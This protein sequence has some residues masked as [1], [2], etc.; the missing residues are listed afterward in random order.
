MH[1]DSALVSTAQAN[2]LCSFHVM[3]FAAVKQRQRV[4]SSQPTVDNSNYD[5]GYIMLPSRSSRI[6]V[7]RFHECLCRLQVLKKLW[8]SKFD[9]IRCV[10]EICLQDH[11]TEDRLCPR[12][13]R[14]IFHA[15]AKSDRFGYMDERSTDGCGCWIDNSEGLGYAIASGFGADER[16][17]R[18]TGKEV[19]SQSQSDAHASCSS[20]PAP[21]PVQTLSTD[22]PVFYLSSPSLGLGCCR[23]CLECSFAGAC[24][25]PASSRTPYTHCYCSSRRL[26]ALAGTAGAALSGLLGPRFL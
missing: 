17:S 4:T 13:G 14:K 18:W 15:E 21:V 20:L 24:S 9:G 2:R 1:N 19:A 26:L 8:Y 10:T 3:E 22:W 25:Q 11:T 12:E 23:S 6:D 16:M 5:A 7:S